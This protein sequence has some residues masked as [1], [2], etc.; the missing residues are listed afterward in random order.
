MNLREMTGGIPIGVKLVP[1]C[2]E[3][4]IECALDAG[5]DFITIDGA[6]AGTKES[7]PILQDDIGLPT[8][9]GLVRA[10]KVLEEKKARHQV[11]IIVSGGLY[12]PGDYLKAIALGADAVALGTVILL[13]AIHTQISKV[14]PWEPLSQ[15]AWDE[16]DFADLLDEEKAAKQVANLLK[17][18]V[19]EMELAVMCLGKKSIHE[20]SR[21]DLVALDPQTA[22]I[23]EVPLAYERQSPSSHR[24]IRP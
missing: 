8:L 21:D 16:G 15:L 17:S 5:V 22:R 2:I 24:M 11:S 6:Q 3:E 1:A 20:V 23:A 12:T 10:V 19:K 4:D 7:A 9:R 14:L 13:A 18:S